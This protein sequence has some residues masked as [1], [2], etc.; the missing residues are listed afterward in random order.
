M[1]QEKLDKILQQHKL[2]LKSEGWQGERANLSGANLKYANLKYA[3]LKYA[4]LKYANLEGA[5][6]KYANLWGANLEG[7][8]LKYANLKYAN[9]EGAN[10]KYANLWGANLEGANLS[11]ANLSRANL[12]GAKLRGAKLP[13][14]DKTPI[15]KNIHQK[16]YYA[17]NQEDALDMSDWHS[18][19]G[20]VHCWAGWIVELAGEDGKRLEEMTDTPIAAALILMKSDPELGEIPDWY[21]DK[22]TALS[23]MKRLAELE[24]AR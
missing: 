12:E 1:E 22:E 8:N 6:L 5:N 11:R 4:N 23:K 18:D 13:Y 2:W 9:L 24:A 15:I 14:F 3:N 19:C 21:S 16:V 7:A 17:A 20:T 10:L